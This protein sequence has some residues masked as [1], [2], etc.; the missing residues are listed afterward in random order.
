MIW[1]PLAGG[2]L[3]TSDTLQAVRVRD[4]LT[5][6]AARH[7]VSAS[8]MAFAWLLRHPSRPIPVAGSRRIDAMRDAVSALDV[9]IDAQ[10]WTEIWA[11]STG[12]EVP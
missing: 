11:A 10:D 6:V 4:A 5:A 9:T 2:R 7:G 12:H 1:S 8:T 3:F